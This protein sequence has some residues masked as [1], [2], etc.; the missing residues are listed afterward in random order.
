MFNLG[1]PTSILSIY[2]LNS[3]YSIPPEDQSVEFVFDSL[4]DNVTHIIGESQLALQ[5][6]NGNWAY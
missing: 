4:G 6:P 5:L 2:N 3:L 1:N